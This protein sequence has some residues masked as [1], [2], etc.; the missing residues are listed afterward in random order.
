MLGLEVV[1]AD[2]RVWNGLR[3]LKKDNTG[4]DLKQLFVGSEGTLGIITAVLKL[5][6]PV[7]E[8]ATAF[9]ALPRSEALG[10]LFRRA[11]ERARRADRLRVHGPHRLEFVARHAPAVRVPVPIAGPG[12]RSSKSPGARTA[13]R[14]P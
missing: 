10:D 11:E 1:L 13:G 7:A 3:S 8:R 14:P 6:A 5:V 2:G 9:A 12:T 4:Y